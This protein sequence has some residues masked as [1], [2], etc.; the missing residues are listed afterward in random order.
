MAMFAGA[1]PTS[2]SVDTLL[3]AVS[4]VE[5]VKGAPPKRRRAGSKRASHRG[6]QPRGP[7]LSPASLRLS[8]Y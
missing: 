1:P 8:P 6:R 4:I 7:I 3:V 2:T 5:S